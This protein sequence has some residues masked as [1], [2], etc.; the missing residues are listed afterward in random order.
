MQT[1]Q[2]LF[3]HELND[4]LDCERQLLETLRENAGVLARGPEKSI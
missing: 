4:L 2:E 1:G 3:V